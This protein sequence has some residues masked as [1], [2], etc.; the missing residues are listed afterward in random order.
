M[1]LARKLALLVAVPLIAVLGY[2]VLALITSIGQAV[3]SDRLAEEVS[4]ARTA[5]ELT[6]DLHRERLASL[7]MLQ[8]V[9][10][11]VQ[12]KEFDR[13]AERTDEHAAEFREQRAALS[14]VPDHFTDVLRRLDAALDDLPDLRAQ[15][16]DGKN[17]NLSAI[18]F[19]YRITAAD[20]ATLRE[21]VSTGAPAELT[22]DLRAAAQFSRITEHIG[23][24][25]IAVLRAAADPYLTPAMEDEVRAARS[26]VVD[27][28]YAFGQ[29]APD[30]WRGWYDRA[31]VGDEARA[32]QVMDDNV[33]RT[34]PNQKVVLDTSAWIT[35]VNAQLDQLSAVERRVDDAVVASVMD[36][37]D[38]QQLRTLIEASVVVL[39]LAAALLIAIWLGAPMIRGLR[40]LRTAAH[41]AAYESLPAAVFALRKR[42][43]LGKATPKEY[44]DAA[45]VAVQVRGKDEIAQVGAAINELN[46]S[47]IHLA[48]QQTS[49]R[50]QVD[51]MFVALARRAERLTSAL[52]A[53]VDL[54]ENREQDPDRLAELFK[55]D[56]LATRMRRTN[57]SLLVL[58]GE[59]SARVRKDAM[60]CHD[61]LNAAAAQVERYPQVDI[62]SEVEQLDLDRVVAA[63]MT[64]HLAHL[65]AELIDNATSF[66]APNSRV[67]VVVRP[68]GD[69]ATVTVTDDGI[70]FSPEALAATKARLADPDSDPGAVRAM[71]LAVVGRIASWYGID[72]DI[73][74]TPK[75]G[76]VVTVSLPPR[77]FTRRTDFDWF[78][79]Q[80]RAATPST[81]VTTP[82]PS[83]ASAGTDKRDPAKISGVMTAFA[84][85]IGAHRSTNAPV[86][87]GR[88][89]APDRSAPDLV[90]RS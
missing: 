40:Q 70:G 45:G 46:H 65:F 32:V 78:H 83:V 63:E 23:L 12:R 37:R 60:S 3:D 48:A 73:S 81:I 14:T 56:H 9:P 75:K 89:A 64:D 28:A 49:L 34:A 80:A 76:T 11:A 82:P 4:L 50:D 27:A 2:A 88:S 16:R 17:A 22:A 68:A 57:N 85:G 42:N 69:G 38:T 19:R 44:A 10:D 66:S 5:G 74:S 90:E 43:S 59:G 21:R 53:Q 86:S 52:I 25:Q 26:G 58:G 77:V 72:I 6:H 33:A 39:T 8:N 62:H 41:T 24:K 35:A 20:L 47:A 55:L 13:L 29:G 67:A 1:S 84:R 7:A 31:R 15:V 71:G 30:T 36:Y 87:D 51:S 61:L 54:A 79:G 18:T